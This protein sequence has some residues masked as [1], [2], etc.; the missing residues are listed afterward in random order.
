[1]R[2]T[3]SALLAVAALA[4]AAVACAMPST[5]PPYDVN[6]INQANAQAASAKKTADHAVVRDAAR[7]HA[8]AAA[9]YKPAHAG[10]PGQVKPYALRPVA[11]ERWCMLDTDLGREPLDTRT[12]H[13]LDP[14]RAAR[15]FAVLMQ[16]RPPAG[17]AKNNPGAV[18]TTWT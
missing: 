9:S 1:M 16:P 14:D 5:P 15:G 17:R 10:Y 8:A 4:A 13:G 7:E 11:T 6:P 12:R 18:L 2:K 3:F